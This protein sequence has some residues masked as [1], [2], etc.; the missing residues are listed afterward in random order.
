MAQRSTDPDWRL[1]RLVQFV[2][3]SESIADMINRIRGMSGLR[4]YPI[5][6]RNNPILSRRTE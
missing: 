4:G 5:T 3:P 2:Y 1:I 6:I